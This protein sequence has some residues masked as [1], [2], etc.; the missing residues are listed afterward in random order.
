MKMRSTVR[1]WLGAIATL[2]VILTPALALAQQS[3]SGSNAV[4]VIR[5]VAVLLYAAFYVYWALAI[6]TIAKKTNTEDDWWA[7]IPI[8][9]LVLLVKI[10]GKPL[11]WTI[12]LFI[13]IV[14]LVFTIIIW[15]GVCEARGKSGLPVIG[16]ILPVVN[17]FVLGYLAFAD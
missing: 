5:I 8:L 13:P 10:A 16:L 1:L 15:V 6:Q 11:W 9:N 7:W 2:A 12:L 4:L 17:F 3:D 14:G